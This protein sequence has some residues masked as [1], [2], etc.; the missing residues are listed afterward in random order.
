MTVHTGRYVVRRGGQVVDA[1]VEW[2]LGPALSGTDVAGADA[3]AVWH[4]DLPGVTARGDDYTTDVLDGQ[5]VTVDW[6]DDDGEVRVFTGLVDSTSGESLTEL[7]SRL[8]DGTQGRLSRV[9]DLRPTAYTLPVHSSLA[10]HGG[11]P[12]RVGL[13]G[14]WFTHQ[15]M[16]A[17]GYD[18]GVPM[19]WSSVWY[20]SMCGSTATVPWRLHAWAPLGDLRQAHRL[21]DH[22]LAPGFE[23][24]D[25]QICAY[26]VST[27]GV[28]TPPVSGTESLPWQVTVDMGTVVPH[29]THGSS[30]EVLLRNL[31]TAAGIVL[32][33]TATQV[34]VRRHA[35][36]GART[37]LITRARDGEARWSV[38][39]AGSTVRLW[40][41]RGGATHVA[42]ATST[43]G[44]PTGRAG[45]CTVRVSSPGL[46]GPVAVTRG[47]RSYMVT[48]RPD[49]HIRRH[50]LHA[51]SLPG[52][53][54][55][56]SVEAGRVLQD[57]SDAERGLRGQPVWS[58]IDS[59][60]LLQSTD[61]A[62]L[63]AQ[64]VSMT[65]DTRPGTGGLALDLLSWQTEPP[66]GPWSGVEVTTQG[67]VVTR[68]GTPSLLLAEGSRETLE[69][70]DDYEVFL[71]PESGT[72]W[73]EPD[74]SPLQAGYPYP[75]PPYPSSYKNDLNRRRRT[76]VGGARLDEQSGD[77]RGWLRPREMGWGVDSKGHV[78]GAMR[79]LDPDTVVV[80]GRA[81]LPSGSIASTMPDQ[82]SEGLWHSRR[83]Q[84]L[85]QLRGYGLVTV[86]DHSVHIPIDGVDDRH[87]PYRHDAGMWVQSST[88]LT[89]MASLLHDAL[90]RPTPVRTAQVQATGRVRPGMKIGLVERRV[91]GVVVTEELVVARLSSS[92]LP[93]DDAMTLTGIVT[94]RSVVQTDPDGP[95][96]DDDDEWVTLPPDLIPAPPPLTD[97]PPVDEPGHEDPA[98]SGP[99]TPSE[100]GVSVV[101]TEMTVEWDG[102]ALDGTPG[103]T[104]HH[105]T[106]EVAV[107]PTPA[108]TDVVG[109][110][111]VAEDGSHRLTTRVDLAETVY[112]RIRLVDRHGTEGPWSPTVQVDVPGV[113]DDSFVADLRE[114]LDEAS[115][116][117]AESGAVLD[118]L[119]AGPGVIPQS[120][121]DRL[122][123]NVVRSRQITT[124]M[125]VVGSGV[126]LVPDPHLVDE[127]L[128]ATRVAASVGS[129]TVADNAA[130]GT[131][132]LRYVAGAEDAFYPVEAGHVYRV[133]Y[134]HRVE[135]ALTGARTR[136]VVAWVDRSGVV[137]TVYPGAYVAPGDTWSPVEV[138][139]AAPEAAIGAWVGVQATTLT[140]S[141]PSVRA[142]GLTSKTDASLIVDGS[143][144]ARHINA[145]S[146]AAVLG[147]FVNVRAE[148][149][150]AGEITAALTISAQGAVYAGTLATG[151]QAYLD[152]TGLGYRVLAE[153]GVTPITVAQMG[154]ESVY[155]DSAGEVTAS[156]TGHDGAVTG[157]QGDFASLSVDGRDVLVEL[158]Y[159][160]RPIVHDDTGI[161]LRGPYS[162]NTGYREVGFLAKQGHLYEIENWLHVLNDTSSERT[163]FTYL[164]L[165][166]A[167]IGAPTVPPTIDH[168]TYGS[169]DGRV[170]AGAEGRFLMKGWFT[171][172]SSDRNVRVLTAARM[173]GSDTAF[174]F[175]RSLFIVKDWGPYEPLVTSGR[176]S[177]GGASG[178]T[179]DPTPPPRKYTRWYD[180]DWGQ[181]VQIGGRSTRPGT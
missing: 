20:Q 74:L 127:D 80:T 77:R 166:Q 58:W 9:L 175:V 51:M 53:T 37:T 169:N 158:D 54:N 157:R 48:R 14:V 161:A 50:S 174:R 130:T 7:S 35:A 132:T 134:Q 162:T 136:P 8:T 36:S 126:N 155:R 31:A 160:P 114:Q 22:T 121:I 70:G 93:A 25:T 129:W 99:P 86:H 33:W 179:P 52:W 1:D 39:V 131:G 120:V 151:G 88:A 177:L 67:T 108:P 138:E 44:L 45:L 146:I 55:V 61:F 66:G 13:F 38:S 4:E 90:T 178:T 79:M 104:E 29:P 149:I 181:A 28:T 163:I 21:S 154:R 148:N 73:L 102:L 171:Q 81:S 43:I 16:T 153:D 135:G 71:H 76:W 98:P 103:V 144:A 56:P 101:L 63:A 24:G 83:E 116:W 172:A 27:F 68:R 60:G 115:L 5:D 176:F 137:S 164:Y 168:A 47:E 105:G 46:I 142:P 92:T 6:V 64:P 97:P 152:G 57:Q 85:P 117:I 150:L 96:V 95:P 165:T 69:H 110:M 10:G 65:F 3:S 89:R 62:S 18:P 112:V 145:E 19:H 107:G 2:T 159:R 100:P 167:G 11:L 40:S 15:A 156:I 49:G 125:L 91:D 123:V 170:A 139:W 34:L 143:V 118:T 111:V 42:Q 124:D 94:A 113:V 133:R 106:T 75:T 140:G 173:G 128:T 72:A 30:G 122:W 119:L 26:D 41:D 17:A 32:E 12:R 23:Q 141:G 59:D 82:G 87:A 180:F 147:E 84:P 78:T 109:T